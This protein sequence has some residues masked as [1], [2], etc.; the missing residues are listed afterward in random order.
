VAL[1]VRETGASCGKQESGKDKSNARIEKN[2]TG[3]ERGLRVKPAMTD[4]FKR[5]QVKPSMT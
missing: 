4:A 2:R 5:L 3:I 1:Y